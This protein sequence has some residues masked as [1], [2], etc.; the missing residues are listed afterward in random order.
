[1]LLSCPSLTVINVKVTFK[2]WIYEDEM[3]KIT[4]AKKK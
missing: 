2:Y 3:M 1:M 4:Q